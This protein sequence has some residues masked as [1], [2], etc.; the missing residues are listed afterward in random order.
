MDAVR[1]ASPSGAAV[2]GLLAGAAR[3]PDRVDRLN[4]LSAVDAAAALATLPDDEAVELL[5]EPELEHGAAILS[6][7]P[8]NRA[9]R[10]LDLVMD[11]VRQRLDL[12]VGV[13]TGDD[14]AIEERGQL[15]RVDDF[16]VFRLDVFEGVDSEFL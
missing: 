5:D 3:T 1:N 12:T 14:D 15:G 16:D 10:F 7:L 13:T 11:V 2:V 9:A 4:S 6:A 8:P